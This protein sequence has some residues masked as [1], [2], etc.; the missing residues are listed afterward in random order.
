MTF[1]F[2]VNADADQWENAKAAFV[3]EMRTRLNSSNVEVQARQSRRGAQL[4]IDL[5]A[6]V[7]DVDAAI[8]TLD[9]MQTE[10]AE[11]TLSIAGVQV[12]SM[13]DPIQTISTG[14]PVETISPNIVESG[15]ETTITITGSADIPYDESTRILVEGVSATPVLITS[16]KLTLDLTPQLLLGTPGRRAAG[17]AISSQVAVMAKD[18]SSSKIVYQYDPSI[19]QVMKIAPFKGKL[20]GGHG[21]GG[22]VEVTVARLSQILAL[23][24]FDTTQIRCRFG[25]MLVVAPNGEALQN[26][27]ISCLPPASGLAGPI[28]VRMLQA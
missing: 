5:T 16:A 27:T 21:G 18:G 11:G 2:E 3:A 24:D 20:V 13:S 26:G 10:A 19:L 25:P 14:C 6:T 8:S 12:A 7:E 28:T 15:I 17:S 9:T 4:L 23:P 22:E 1:R